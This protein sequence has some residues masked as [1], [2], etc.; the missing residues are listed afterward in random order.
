LTARQITHWI[1]RREVEAHLVVGILTERYRRVAGIREG[2]GGGQLVTR[3]DRHVIDRIN[4]AAGFPVL[5]GV[6]GAAEPALAT[7]AVEA[8]VPAAEAW[9]P[10]AY[11]S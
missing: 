1:I 2:A 4:S 11:R 8:P 6:I 7:G 3:V 5:V 9:A 10:N